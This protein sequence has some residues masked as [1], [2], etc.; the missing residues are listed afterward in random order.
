MMHEPGLRAVGEETD[1]GHT[2]FRY[3]MGGTAPW[4]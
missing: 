1:T 4:L 3:L 2:V